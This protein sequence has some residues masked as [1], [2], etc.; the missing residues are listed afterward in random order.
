MVVSAFIL[1]GCAYNRP[2]FS[3]QVVTTNGIITKRSLSVRTFALWP[4]TTQL[5]K[6]RASLGKTMSLGTTG[7]SEDS[8]GTN[9]AATIEAL[10]KL[11]QTI[12]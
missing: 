1:A 8:G 9:I 10:T 11:L 7:L 12:K 2:L 5:E 6:Q 4:A 3:E